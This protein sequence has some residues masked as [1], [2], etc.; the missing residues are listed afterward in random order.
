MLVKY[1]QRHSVKVSDHGHFL[2]VKLSIH[3]FPRE[4]FNIDEHFFLIL[5]VGGSDVHSG[6]GVYIFTTPYRFADTA[7]INVVLLDR[8]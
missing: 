2:L 7:L 1:Q 6:T 4:L 5:F 8:W 3:A